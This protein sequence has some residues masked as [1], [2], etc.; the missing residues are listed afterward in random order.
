[1][2]DAVD[3]ACQRTNDIARG[4]RS[5][6]VLTPRRWCQVSRKAMSALTGPTRRYPRGDG[7]KQARSPGRARNKLLK[8]SR[9]EGRCSGEPVVTNSCAFYTL[10]TRLRVQRAP[11]FPCALCFL[12]DK[13]LH[14]SGATRRGNALSHSS[15]VM[16]RF[17]RRIQYAA[18]SR[19]YAHERL[20]NT[21]SPGQ[22]GRRRLSK[23]FEIRIRNCANGHAAA[24]ATTC[25]SNCSRFDCER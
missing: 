22:A 24:V 2:R 8:P 16:P 3:A 18:T 15:V 9:R 1:V 23:L 19:T 17:K 5:R 21:G 20:W 12:G 4:R 7:G 13:F 10:R 11:G 25:A 14:N 6:V